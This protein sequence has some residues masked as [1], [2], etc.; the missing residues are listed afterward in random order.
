MKT[1]TY[2][3][4]LIVDIPSQIPVQ[5][6]QILKISQNARPPSI[7]SLKLGG[8]RGKTCKTPKEK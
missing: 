1:R 4:S 5:Y 2:S 8:K 3:N 6:S 7:D